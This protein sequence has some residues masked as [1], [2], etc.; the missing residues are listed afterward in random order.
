MIKLFCKHEWKIV[1]EITT[2]SRFEV[3]TTQLNN[4]KPKTIP[5]QLCDARRKHIQIVTC[6]KC[7]KLRRFVETI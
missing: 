7:G 5:W 4:T 3:A 2:K 6:D 1:S